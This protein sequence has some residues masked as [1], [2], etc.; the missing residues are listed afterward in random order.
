MAFTETYIQPQRWTEFM[1]FAIGGA[2]GLIS[3]NV[4]PGKIWKLKEVRV[5][6]SSLIASAGD[7]VIQLSSIRNSY[8]NMIFVSK[9]ML[10]SQ[11]YWLQMSDPLIFESDD[12]LNVR[13]SVLSAV[14][15]LGIT[16]VG[17]CVLG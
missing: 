6:A 15:Y 8:L 7:L 9:A 14:N 12:A 2:D 5:H 17:W 13:F 11:D 4:A 1:F 10:N 16:V 3:E